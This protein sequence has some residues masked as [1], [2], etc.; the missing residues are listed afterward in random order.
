MSKCGQY[1]VALLIGVMATNAMTAAT[2]QAQSSR[3]NFIVFIADDMAWN[4]CG[5][6]GHPRIRTPSIDRLAREGMR[7]D[8]A[9]LTCSSCSPSRSSI[10]TGRYPH[11]TGAHQLH[12][13]L[14]G[15]QTT[16]VE[17]LTK[18]GYYTA[19]AGKWHLGEATIP[20]FSTVH[21]KMNMWVSTLQ[22][23]PRDRPFFMWFAFSD[24]HRPYEENTIPRP[25]SPEDVIVPP[26]LPDNDLTRK[27]LALYYDEIGRLD[28]VVGRVIDELEEQGVT[29]ETMIVF[30]SDN[31]RPFPRSKTT[32]YNSGVK[33]PWIVRWPGRVSPGTTCQSM[34]SSIDLAPTILQLA[35]LKP[36]DSFQGVS[37]EPLLDDPQSSVRDFVFAE[38]NWHDFD[39]HGRS[40]RN[41]EFSYMKNYYT[42]VS[43]SPPADAVRSITYQEMIR[44]HAA[45][46]LPLEQATC[47]QVPRPQEELY[48]LTNDPYELN[49]LASEPSYA[50]SLAEM[51]M[52]LDDWERET[53]D[54]VPPSRRPDEFHRQTG[55]RLAKRK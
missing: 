29:N 35:G 3:P 45:G 40:A 42:D 30:L 22:N 32:M 26:F 13:P 18:A 20:K 7:F 51:R 23:R 48:D 10:I 9:Y 41:A 54:S 52:V 6:Y 15:E 2:A 34:V 21:Q 53:G 43:G 14:P 24:P 4:D 19:S 28:S 17:S 49:N 37:F 5:A 46:E 44:L 27:D 55:E 12:M 11:N 25:H 39:D 47:F 33:T 8:N 36:G 38:H 1:F 31:G 50:S 16:F